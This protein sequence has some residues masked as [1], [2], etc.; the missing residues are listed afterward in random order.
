M[1]Q[2]KILPRYAPELGLT[3]VQVDTWSRDCFDTVFNTLVKLVVLV[4]NYYYM[5]TKGQ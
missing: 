3:Q 5:H 4:A 2:S 1:I